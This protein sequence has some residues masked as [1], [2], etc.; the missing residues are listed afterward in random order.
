MPNPLKDRGTR[1][2]LKITLHDKLN[3]PTIISRPVVRN[4]MAV[5]IGLNLKIGK[6]ASYDLMILSRMFSSISQLVGNSIWIRRD[7]ISL[8]RKNRRI[9]R[10]RIKKI[11][12]KAVSYTHLTLPT[13]LRV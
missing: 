6:K 3:L 11:P 8:L 4:K 13:I 5:F 9:S 7:K 1:S 12:S 10:K 2:L